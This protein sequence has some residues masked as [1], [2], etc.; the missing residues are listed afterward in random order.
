M[1]KFSIYS[2]GKNPPQNGTSPFIHTPQKH[3]L[4]K[5]SPKILHFFIALFLFLFS[6]LLCDHCSLNF[7]LTSKAKQK[8]THKDHLFLPPHLISIPNF[9]HVL[10][11]TH[12]ALSYINN[13]NFSPSS[14]LWGISPLF[15]YNWVLSMEIEEPIL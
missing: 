7:A 3:F 2:H 8:H 6:F 9:F 4:D 15:I 1:L 13:H 10:F 5:F 12:F 11:F 14:R